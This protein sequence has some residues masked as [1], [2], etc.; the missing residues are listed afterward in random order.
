MGL[1]AFLVSK[2][3]CPVLLLGQLPRVLFPIFNPHLW[4][5]FWCTN[6]IH[7][8]TCV[9]HCPPWG[10]SAGLRDRW[11]WR[12][13]SGF[14]L[15]KNAG[16]DVCTQSMKHINGIIGTQ[17]IMLSPQVTWIP[18]QRAYLGIARCTSP[19]VTSSSL[20][21]P[22]RC[23]DSGERGGVQAPDNSFCYKQT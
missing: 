2:C 11:L 15:E 18:Q 7:R 21:F 13:D 3:V 22:V 4:Y 20:L 19:P 6:T 17:R 8:H 5:S 12:P 10:F 23:V 16:S 1:A 14:A 9:W